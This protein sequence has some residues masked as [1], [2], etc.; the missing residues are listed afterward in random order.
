MGSLCCT[1]AKYPQNGG[2]GKPISLCSN[3]AI[4]VSRLVFH[5]G[6]FEWDDRYNE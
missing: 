1:F 6:L 3:V 2:V 4:E 5:I